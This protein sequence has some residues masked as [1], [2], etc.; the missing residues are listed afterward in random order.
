M[1]PYEEVFREVMFYMGC[2]CSGAI[3]L[4]VIGIMFSE[5][6]RKGTVQNRIPRV[7]GT[8]SN[9]WKDGF[10][11]EYVWSRH[12]YHGKNVDYLEWLDDMLES[13]HNAPPLWHP[14]FKWGL[15][16]NKSNKTLH[17][18]WSRIISEPVSNTETKETTSYW[19]EIR[20]K[21][22]RSHVQ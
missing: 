17:L 18:S 2:S 6:F 11:W 15:T 16:H 22:Y 13:S 19:K 9:T 8:H 7:V 5:I 12:Q 1:Q 10:C 3:I 14:S 20:D 21:D 4:M